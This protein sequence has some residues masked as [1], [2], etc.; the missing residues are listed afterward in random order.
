[1]QW[2]GKQTR[3]HGFCWRVLFILFFF[4]LMLRDSFSATASRFYSHTY[5]HTYTHELAR[6]RSLTFSHILH[7]YAHKILPSF[8]V[9]LGEILWFFR[10]VS[11]CR[12]LSSRIEWATVL[13]RYCLF[14]LALLCSVC[15]C[16]SRGKYYARVIQLVN[17][18]IRQS[19]SLQCTVYL[20]VYRASFCWAF[21]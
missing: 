21:K 15:C 10:S 2:S 8:M 3:W 14:C 6:P 5:T 17:N 13:V 16:S 4:L 7:R 1:M 20:S 12:S 19:V 11:V 18:S 9:L